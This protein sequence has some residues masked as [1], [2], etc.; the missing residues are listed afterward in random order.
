[1]RGNNKLLLVTT[2]GIVSLVIIIALVLLLSNK[3]QTL[4]CTNTS[5][6]SASGYTLESTYVI[7]SKNNIVKEIKIEEVIT[8][9]DQDVL[10]R[11]EDQFNEQYE[12]NKNTYGGYE[13]KVI[14]KDNKVSTDVLIKY[15]KVDM[16]IIIS[17]NEAMKEYTKNDKLTLS[18][19]KTMYE[20]SG[21]TC[22]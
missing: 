7:K 1:M 14:N 9:E 21:A 18:G 16:K 11:F 22:K 13:Y 4:T 3:T 2:I 8:S 19:A 12:Y 17:N 10:K 6:Q 5:N 15:T 20:K